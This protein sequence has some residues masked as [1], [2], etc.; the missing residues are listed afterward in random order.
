MPD[1]ISHVLTT[2]SESLVMAMP[3]FACKVT[4]LIE[5]EGKGAG[6]ILVMIGSI[7]EVPICQNLID[8]SS[9]AEIREEG[10]ENIREVML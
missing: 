10:E 9:D 2:P 1:E 5:A 8:P 6:S 3:Y 4:D 7:D